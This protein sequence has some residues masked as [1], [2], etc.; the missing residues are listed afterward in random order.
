MIIGCFVTTGPGNTRITFGGHG[1]S[2]LLAAI[3]EILMAVR[4][5]ARSFCCAFSC[6]NREHCP[7]NVVACLF[8]KV[9]PCCTVWRM[10]SVRMLPNQTPHLNQFTSNKKH[11]KKKHRNWHE[12]APG[13]QPTS[14]IRGSAT[15][16]PPSIWHPGSPCMLTGEGVKESIRVLGSRAF[17]ARGGW[18]R[19]GPWWQGHGVK[20][21][22][23]S[24]MAPV[25]RT[26]QAMEL[27]LLLGFARGGPNRWTKLYLPWHIGNADPLS[28]CFMMKIAPFWSSLSEI[29][30][31][32]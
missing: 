17:E 19:A 2:C 22:L 10:A 24:D 9:V 12:T 4:S 28:R 25:S 20:P 15:F 6:I 11:D 7:K 1:S 14:V 8:C 29:T 16:S 31:S 5:I 32:S 26:I 30:S 23:K 3:P 21:S 13:M 27:F 18:M